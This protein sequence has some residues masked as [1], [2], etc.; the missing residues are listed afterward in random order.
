M[1]LPYGSLFFAA[2]IDFEEKAPKVGQAKHA[3]V[4][5]ILRGRQKLGYFLVYMP[6]HTAISC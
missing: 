4:I 3:A 5:V 2:A 1:L 6:T